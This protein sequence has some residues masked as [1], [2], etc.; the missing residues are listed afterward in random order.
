MVI[1]VSRKIKVNIIFRVLYY[2]VYEMLGKEN[3]ENLSMN[4]VIPN[5]TYI[6]YEI[7]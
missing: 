6:M 4:V 7:L 3:A 1:Q 5:E 2:I